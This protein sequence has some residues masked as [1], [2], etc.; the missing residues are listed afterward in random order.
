M[1]SS[2]IK[3]AR[4]GTDEARSRLFSQV[5]ELVIG[6]CEERTDRELAI[7]CEVALRLY[8]CGAEPDRTKLSRQL[9]EQPKAPRA[10]AK[11]IAR[12][13]V[14][15]AT[16]V[17][18]NCPAFTH[19]DLLEFI[20]NLSKVHLQAI[21]RRKDLST[22][23]SDMLV[24]SG[25][26]PVCRILAANNDVRLSRDT[27]LEFAKLCEDD[28]MLREDFALRNDLPPAVCRSLLPM[29]D[30]AT[31]KHLHAIL[32][33]S[34]SQEQREQIARLKQLRSDF[35]TELETSDISQLWRNAEQ[36]GITVDELMILLL[37]DGRFEHAVELLGARGRT[38]R[39]VFREA[40]IE[41]KMDRVIKTSVKA[42]LS[43]PTF[44]MFAKARCAQLNLPQA[45]A[46]EWT[47]A[48]V[49]HLAEV[50]TT[51]QSRSG[52]FQARRKD[53]RVRPSTT[54]TEQLT[55]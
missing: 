47:S 43:G 3:L 6:N 44:A 49:A 45:E 18:E 1:Q 5:S 16:P 23:L 26:M 53:K 46:S 54:R 37:Q 17:L 13:V 51:K 15:V 41:G 12:D 9:S 52:D 33:G 32:E 14:G 39:R 4:D 48:Y 21:A 24:K 7:Y 31:K 8:E 11:R 34:L 50:A 10:L 40:V 28:I 27:M 30:D 22:E 20:A 19:D 38:A 2:L 55:A 29:V 36:A 42:G 35:G 25:D